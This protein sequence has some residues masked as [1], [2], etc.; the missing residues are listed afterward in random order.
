MAVA[1]AAA[2]AVVTGGTNA[3]TTTA[4]TSLMS[5][6]WA[7]RRLS[8]P[9]AGPRKADTPQAKGSVATSVHEEGNTRP[10]DRL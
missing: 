5:S 2:E 8:L 10:K 1:T 9:S 4:T 7:P 3:V 6:C